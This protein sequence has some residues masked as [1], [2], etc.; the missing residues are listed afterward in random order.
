MSSVQIP[1]PAPYRGGSHP[2]ARFLFVGFL[3]RDDLALYAGTTYS[4]AQEG[5]A[6]RGIG[7]IAD[8]V[9]RRVPVQIV[10]YAPPGFRNAFE[11]A[12]AQQK[13]PIRKLV[14]A[15]E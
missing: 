9:V 6:E 13:R 8:T 11:E 2:A 3:D 5:K 12:L 15:N 14:A 1:P 4:F 10:M 7:V